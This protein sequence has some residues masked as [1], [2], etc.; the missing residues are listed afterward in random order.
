[1]TQGKS[2]DLIRKIAFHISA[3]AIFAFASYSFSSPLHANI[4]LPYKIV[5]V[6]N[7]QTR[8]F[9]PMVV[10]VDPTNPT[11]IYLL[12][13][14]PQPEDNRP[15]VQNALPY[16]YFNVKYEPDLGIRQL[17]QMELAQRA[18]HDLNQ[19][20]DRVRYANT[21]DPNLSSIKSIGTSTIKLSTIRLQS[22]SANLSVHPATKALVSILLHQDPILSA[23][24]E[25]IEDIAPEVLHKKILR[26]SERM[27]LSWQTQKAELISYIN[28]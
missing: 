22:T 28:Q 27:R 1:M 3:F 16:Q 25:A 19:L 12:L 5:M 14:R 11:Y 17:D 8:E 7:A 20:I 26:S 24:L 18:I 2:S 9:E 10:Y 23:E 4:N 21:R 13:T 15:P 6:Q